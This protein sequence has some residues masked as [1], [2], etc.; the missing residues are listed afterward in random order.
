MSLGFVGLGL[1]PYQYR[2]SG[3]GTEVSSTTGVLTI[4]GSYQ[5]G[6]S[7]RLTAFNATTIHRN[8]FTDTGL[9]VKTDSF[10]FFDQRIGVYLM[11]GANFF[12]F[13]F[14]SG[15][16]FKGG[17][18]QGF[19]AVIRDFLYANRS[20]TAGAFIYP[21]IDGKSYYNVWLRYGSSKFF[22]ELNYI[23]IRD[24][25]DD[26]PVYTRSAGVSVGFPF[27]RLF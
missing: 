13:K 19:E 26:R 5:L 15:T 22:G 11:F 1:G 16:R 14:D 20:L 2:L 25:F 3:A 24:R 18:P 9:Y 17:A 8:F 27:A 12:G 23:S 21:P 4:Y 6:E 7:V 10:R